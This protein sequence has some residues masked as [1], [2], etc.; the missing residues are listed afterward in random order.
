MREAVIIVSGNHGAGRD[1]AAD[2][3]ADRL[4]SPGPVLRRP[5]L[6]VELPWRIGTLPG[7]LHFTTPASVVALVAALSRPGAT[8]LLHDSD[9]TSAP[10]SWRT[11]LAGTRRLVV[12][13]EEDAL[14]VRAPDEHR[15]GS[16]ARAA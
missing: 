4:R 10:G 15:S 8:V 1:A 6:T 5:H 7:W 2:A 9:R 3:R 11:A 12:Q 13:R 16:R 14:E